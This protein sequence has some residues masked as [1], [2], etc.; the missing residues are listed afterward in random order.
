MKVVNIFMPFS[1]A[2]PVF[3]WIV[4]PSV[5]HWPNP[6]PNPNIN[7]EL[8][9]TDLRLNSELPLQGGIGVRDGAGGGGAQLPSPNHD[10]IW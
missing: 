5:G 4:S 3:S 2:N 1:R 6:N 8:K 10:M 7:I 9:Q